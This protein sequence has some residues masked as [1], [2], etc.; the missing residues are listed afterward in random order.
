MNGYRCR[1]TGFHIGNKHVVKKNSGFIAFFKIYF[2]HNK[3]GLV[4]SRE[5]SHEESKGRSTE[6]KER[7]TG[8]ESERFRIFAGVI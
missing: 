5:K 4:R 7:E 3:N 1:N 2:S 8:Q 6:K